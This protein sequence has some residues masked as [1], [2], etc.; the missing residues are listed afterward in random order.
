MNRVVAALSGVM[1]IPCLAQPSFAQ[2]RPVARDTASF[3]VASVRPHRSADDLMFALQF[4]DGGRVTATGTL[5]MLIRTAYRLQE[6]QVVGLRGWIDD[7]RFDV[8][9]RAGRD[10]TPDEMRVMLRGLLRERFG[11]ALR[12]ERRDSPVY[13]LRV[14]SAA[15]G[16]GPAMRPAVET[17]AAGACNLRFAPGVLSAR[18]VTMTIL[19]RELS[20]W[21]D[22][23]VTDQTGLG[24]TFDLDLEWAPDRIP[25]APAVVSTPE[26]PVAARVDSNAPSIFT[27][28]REQ[29]GLSLEPVRGEVDV[30]VI[31][32]AARPAA[33]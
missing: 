26:P 2:D 15:R 7:E 24:D 31:D 30:L 6:F 12:S 25:Q 33:N 14:A 13:A 8:E 20:S 23:I 9:G 5:R 22:R 19:A 3:D 27:A 11:L 18:G 4:H 28:V 32:R 10:A 29:L 21:V 17:C 1:L 16:L